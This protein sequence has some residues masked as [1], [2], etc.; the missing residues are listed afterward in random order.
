MNVIHK[1]KAMLRIKSK[2]NSS[3]SL[4]DRAMAV[5]EHDSRQEKL[6]SEQKKFSL[7]ECLDDTTLNKDF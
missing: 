1:C 5:L 4:K 7:E 6:A 2:S 3:A